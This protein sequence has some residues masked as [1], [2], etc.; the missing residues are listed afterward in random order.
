MNGR[1]LPTNIKN[2]SVRCG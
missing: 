1:K 2:S